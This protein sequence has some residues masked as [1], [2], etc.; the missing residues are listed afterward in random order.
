MTTPVSS[1]STGTHKPYGFEPQPYGWYFAE[2]NR[3]SIG[4]ADSAKPY[5]TPH[6]PVQQASHTL[7]ACTRAM[8]IGAR[9]GRAREA[10]IDRGDGIA[11]DGG[12]RVAKAPIEDDDLL[13]T[14]EEAEEEH[15][16]LAEAIRAMVREYGD[17]GDR[18][19]N[20]DVP[21][22]ALDAYRELVGMVGREAEI[23][24]SS[25]LS[26]IAQRLR[27]DTTAVKG[28]VIAPLQNAG[29]VSVRGSTIVVHQEPGEHYDDDAGHHDVEEVSTRMT[30]S[31]THYRCRRCGG[32]FES[33]QL[34]SDRPCEVVDSPADAAADD[35]REV[36]ADD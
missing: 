6:R 30:K 15:G 4:Q 12:K 35:T 1:G 36:P 21:A 14:L 29:Y 28:S 17:D 32:V 23:D 24:E 10:G 26:L 33:K 19:G 11:T 13:A 3:H 5:G 20:H 18:A 25:A 16:S 34:L 2:T 27:V 7:R 8:A 22:K 31:I 9:W